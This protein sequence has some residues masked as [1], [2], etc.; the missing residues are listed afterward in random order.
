MEPEFWHNRWQQNQI[1]FHRGETNPQLERF[2]PDLAIS[3]PGRV[4]VPLCGKTLDMLWLA[5]QGWNVLGVELSS[6]AVAAFFTENRLEVTRTRIGEFEVWQAGQIEI[7]CGD[8][9]ALRPHHA[10]QVR[11]IYDRAALIALP[12][13]KRAQYVE[14]LRAIMPANPPCLLVSLEYPQHEMSGPPFSVDE[15]EI[16]HLY[17]SM[18]RIT[19]VHQED[20][21]EPTSH[22]R[23]KGVTKMTEVVYELCAP[24]SN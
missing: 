12:P 8:L 20:A 9:F 13:E 19:R 4:F 1:G 17:E 3:P 16:R 21:L 6:I 24:R 10:V 22:F 23:D 11:A 15:S 18:Y 7:Y 14:H 5:A 2:W